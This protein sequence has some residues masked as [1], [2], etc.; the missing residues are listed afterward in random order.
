MK[1]WM[2]G[3]ILVLCCLLSACAGFPES[4]AETG[5]SPGT[6]APTEP[7]ETDT[8]IETESGPETEPETEPETGMTE[9]ERE[10]LARERKETEEELA[11]LGEEIRKAEEAYLEQDAAVALA[12]QEFNSTMEYYESVDGGQQTMYEMKEAQKAKMRPEEEKRDR[13]LSKLNEL[14]GRSVL[15]EERLRTLRERES[16]E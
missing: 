11:R 1:G 3:L 13:L 9:A 16:G 5:T 7:A 15:L 8:G 10:A 14:Y 4:G 12:W 6:D 2:A